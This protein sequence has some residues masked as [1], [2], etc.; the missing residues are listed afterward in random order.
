VAEPDRTVAEN[1]R[2]KQEV[3]D[4]R[5]RIAAF[6]SSRWWRLHPRFLLRGGKTATPRAERVAPPATA[7]DDGVASRFRAEV[8]DRGTFSEDWFTVHIPEWTRILA[9]L[10]GRAVR[11]L[12]LGSYEG[13]SA[14]FVLWRLPDA[15]V[16]CIDTFAG[17]EGY[18]PYGIETSGL[19]E[20]F[21]ANVA[22]IDASRVRKLVGTT[23]ALL[24][25]LVAEQEGYD[26]IYV[27]ASHTALDVLAD[28]AL[29]WQLLVDG[30]V[31]IFDD[32]GAAPPGEDPLL[33]PKP[34]IDAFV[35]L[36]AP[37]LVSDARQLAVRKR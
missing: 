18:T 7:A 14:C 29:A 17:I 2:L 6:E 8:F 34:A 36:V 19:D 3:R 31:M 30:G 37:E 13:L 1:Q 4:L 22:L 21:D 26:L 5:E 28:V 27:D 35:R 15:H 10:E 9:P 25:Q 32:Y 16:T 33:Y 11:V 12:E 23:H 24:P 20:R